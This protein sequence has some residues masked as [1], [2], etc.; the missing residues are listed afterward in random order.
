M[1]IIET[2]RVRTLLT[3]M[4]LEFGLHWVVDEVNETIALGVVEPK[5]LERN[6][7]QGVEQYRAT[8]ENQSSKR[9]G[10]QRALEFVSHREMLEPEKLTTLIS[11]LKVVLVDLPVIAETALA[12]LAEN[13]NGQGVDRNSEMTKADSVVTG[14]RFVPELEETR[15]ELIDLRTASRVNGID[16]IERLLTGLGREISR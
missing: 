2:I 15:D 16:D 13:S 4:A 1:E 14:V 5:N 11:A 9:R 7:K 10:R 8:G 3:E 12:Y 6:V